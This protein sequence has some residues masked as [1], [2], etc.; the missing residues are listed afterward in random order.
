M[1]FFQETARHTQ[2]LTGYSLRSRTSVQST[3]L[4]PFGKGK[5]VPVKVIKANGEAEV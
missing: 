1:G 5:V 3:A 2:H 4:N